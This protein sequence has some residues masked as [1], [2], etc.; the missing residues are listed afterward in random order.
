MPINVLYREREAGHILRDASPKALVSDSI[1]SY[2]GPDFSPANIWSVDELATDAAS[3]P[4][5]AADTTLDAATP[6]AIIYTSGTTGAA[7]GAVITHGAL[8]AN[9]RNLVDAWRITAADRLLLALPLF[10]VHGLGNGVHSW[11]LSGCRTRLLERF[12]HRSAAA[13]F[14]D[15]R[16]TLFF[17][18]PTMYVRMLEIDESAARAIGGALRLCV[19]GSAPLPA[20]V[21]EEFDARFGQR[22]LERYGMT[23]TLM[24]LGNPYDGERRAGTVG[25]PFAGVTARI[26]TETDDAA[27]VGVPGELLVKSPTLFAGYWNRPDATAAAFRDGWFATGDIAERSAD[28]YYTLCGR[29]SDLII[30]GGFNIYP[31]EIEEVLADHPAVAEVAVAGMADRL[32]GEVPVAF[33]VA[34]T[35]PPVDAAELVDYCAARLAS[36]KVPREVRFLEALPRNAMG[37]VE[38]KRLV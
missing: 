14:L 3:R 7:K 30:S 34:R 9:A 20:Q 32:K 13:T 31:R 37:K 23:E 15:F 10:H 19:S 28:G 29:K 8:A 38:K 11:L 22:I 16:P 18:V 24:T 1:E 12:D 5:I 35:E 6:A 27:P 2:V 26:A 4:V 25:Q 33:V 36:F 21:L 17:G